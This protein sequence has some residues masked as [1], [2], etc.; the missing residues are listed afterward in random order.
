MWTRIG[1]AVILF[2]GLVSVLVQAIAFQ[3]SP[4]IGVAFLDCVVGVVGIFSAG[5]GSR[6]AA[7]LYLVLSSLRLLAGIALCA[8][9]LG[10]F[11]PSSH[12]SALLCKEASLV[13]QELSGTPVSDEAKEAARAACAHA[14]AV[15]V[16]LVATALVLGATLFWYPCWRCSLYLREAMAEKEALEGL[17]RETGDGDDDDYSYDKK[18]KQGKK[19]VVHELLGPSPSKERGNS[20][21]MDAHD[22]SMEVVSPPMAV[23]KAEEV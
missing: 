15:V 4:L 6:R 11:D 17:L 1:G 3:G 10:I 12:L 21:E 23:H 7:T 16:G 2:C 5:H 22:I 18:N 9:F 20:M 19:S 13:G 14:G 8:V